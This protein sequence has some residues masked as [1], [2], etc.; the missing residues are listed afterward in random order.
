MKDNILVELSIEFAVIKMRSCLLNEQN[1][2]IMEVIY[3]FL[4]S[5]NYYKGF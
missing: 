1:Y 2:L 4:S 5:Y 3:A